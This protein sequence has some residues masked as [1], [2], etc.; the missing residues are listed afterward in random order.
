ML[1]DLHISHIR[2]SDLRYLDIVKKKGVKRALSLRILTAVF[3]DDIEK[4]VSSS[5]VT[6]IHT[7]SVYID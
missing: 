5:F 7:T 1:V 3:K 2:G 6:F 4:Q